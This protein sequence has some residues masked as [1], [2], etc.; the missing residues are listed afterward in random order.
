M[1]RIKKHELAK[2][3]TERAGLDG[4]QYQALKTQQAYRHRLDQMTRRIH[5]EW[6]PE[7]YDFFYDS[8]AE[9]KARQQSLNLPDSQQP[10]QLGDN[11]MS[12]AHIETVKQRRQAFGVAPLDSNGM[13]HGQDSWQI[14]RHEAEQRLPALVD[15]VVA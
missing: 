2:Y 4:L 12:A 5:A 6:F 10:R 13:Y 9:N 11:P 3:N 15:V 8:I 14:A 1:N 7:E